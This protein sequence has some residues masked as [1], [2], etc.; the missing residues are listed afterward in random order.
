MAQPREA[1]ASACLVPETMIWRGWA[2]PKNS[3][4]FRWSTWMPWSTSSS[5]VGSGPDATQDEITDYFVDM[6]LTAGE[7]SG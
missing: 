6:L 7:A 1:M 4:P 2:L 5:Q 3:E